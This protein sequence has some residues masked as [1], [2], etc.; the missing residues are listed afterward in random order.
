MQ[1]KDNLRE[2][3]ED[4]PNRKNIIA[5]FIM[6]FV[7]L[8]TIILVIYAWFLTNHIGGVRGMSF[9]STDTINVTFATYVGSADSNGNVVFDEENDLNKPSTEDNSVSLFP[10][11][12]QYYKT[13]IYN[14]DEKSYNGTMCLE[15]MKVNKN[16]STNFVR[17]DDGTTSTQVFVHFSSQIENRDD[18]KQTF[19]LTRDSGIVD[20]TFCNVAAQNIQSELTLKPA[21]LENGEKV[22]STVTIIWYVELDGDKVTNFDPEGNSV[23]DTE[24][25]KFSSIRFRQD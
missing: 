11:E 3:Q 7:I 15:N 13:I 22:P 23:M 14:N 18:T 16:F 12:K 8:V 10:G 4:A 1:R 5:N 20:E 2:V 21:T 25:M 17:N 9:I 24:L 6:L 19:D